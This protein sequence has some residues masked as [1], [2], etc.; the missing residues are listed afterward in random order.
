MK[1]SGPAGIVLCSCA[2]DNDDS[3]FLPIC[4]SD[5]WNVFSASALCTEVG[6]PGDGS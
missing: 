4:S 2:N 6:L 1:P 3:V 5:L